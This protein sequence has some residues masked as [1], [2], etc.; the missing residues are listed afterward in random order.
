[1]EF[2]VDF[3]HVNKFSIFGY[4]LPRYSI[5]M[6]FRYSSFSHKPGAIL[7]PLQTQKGLKL[8][9]LSFSPE[10]S[11]PSHPLVVILKIAQLGAGFVRMWLRW[12]PPILFRFPLPP[13]SAERGRSCA[14]ALVTNFYQINTAAQIYCNFRLEIRWGVEPLVAK[15][16]SKTGVHSFGLLR[17]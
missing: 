1:M 13:Q 11:L 14:D 3:Q 17:A 5:T 12:Q 2:E 8:K 4:R 7:F 6:F 16:S 15:T 10:D 9:T